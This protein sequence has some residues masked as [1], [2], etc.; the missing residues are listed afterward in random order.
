M[1][2]VTVGGEEFWDQ[3]KEEFVTPKEYTFTIEHSLLSIY[4]WEAKW[5][6]PFLDSKKNAKEFIDYIRCMTLT[7]NVSEEAYS[8]L[9]VKV[10]KEIDA[11][12]SDSMT[13]TKIRDTARPR[14]GQF[15]TA[16]L[17]YSW[18]IKLGIPM[19]WEKRHLNQ[20]LTLIRV[21]SSE[22]TERKM[23]QKEIL[24]QNMALNLARRAKFKTKG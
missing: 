16:E 11:Y 1:Y 6:K 9:T 18:M 12:M 10:I 23:S 21:C 22:G 17:I 4:K 5:H 14:N 19:D 24:E 20:L 2:K 13:A 7:Q 8:L 3:V 15:I